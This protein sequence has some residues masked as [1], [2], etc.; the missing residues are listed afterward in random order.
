MPLYGYRRSCREGGLEGACSGPRSAGDPDGWLPR[1][2]RSCRASFREGPNSGRVRALAEAG[3]LVR[4]VF[5][6]VRETRVG[7]F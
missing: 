2:V 6:S 7:F 4:T 3:F 5:V 1:L